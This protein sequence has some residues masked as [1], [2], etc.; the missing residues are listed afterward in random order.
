MGSG[1]QHFSEAPTHL[2]RFRS[3]FLLGKYPV[4]QG[5]WKAVM[6]NNPSAFCDSPNLP[7]DSVSWDQSAEFCR[8]LSAQ[9]GIRVRLP[10]EAEW[11]YACR[12]GSTGEFCFGPWG[13]FLDDSEVPS[14]ARHALSE[15]A[16][17]P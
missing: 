7:V 9:S 10:S 8:R 11:E 17:A 5:Q 14:T 13:P 12:A 1:N 16:L 4:T 15:F 2:V 6:R 3:G